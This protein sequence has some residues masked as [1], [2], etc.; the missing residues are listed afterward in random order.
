MAIR[1]WNVTLVA[2]LLAA[3]P[4]WGCSKDEATTAAP[5]ASQDS[6]VAVKVDRSPGSGR[7]IKIEIDLDARSDLDIPNRGANARVQ[8][9]DD[10]GVDIQVDLG[11]GGEQPQ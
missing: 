2:A 6:G 9:K 4:L 8:G 7:D 11:G 3:A 1:R 5:A 10:G